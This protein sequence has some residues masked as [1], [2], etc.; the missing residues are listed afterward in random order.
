M[1]VPSIWSRLAS[2]RFSLVKHLGTTGSVDQAGLDC[3]LSLYLG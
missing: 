1:L 3:E 2:F